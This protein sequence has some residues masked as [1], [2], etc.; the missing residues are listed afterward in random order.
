MKE[1]YLE[2]QRSERTKAL[3]LRVVRVRR[4]ESVRRPA[5]L[6]SGRRYGAKVATCQPRT[7]IVCGAWLVGICLMHD[8]D[9]T[10]SAALGVLV[11][12][13]VASVIGLRVDISVVPF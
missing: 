9:F 5:R 6:A 7:W 1:A 13:Q 2:M 10:S 8:E 11:P 4:Y 12:V 3:K